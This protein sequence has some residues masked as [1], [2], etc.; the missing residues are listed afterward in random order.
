MNQR[1]LAAL[2]VLNAV[3]LAAL[4]V[5]VFSPRPAEAQFVGGSQ[6]LMI[7][8]DV[9]G[10]SQQAGVYIANL[11]SGQVLPILFNT[12]NNRLDTFPVRN[13]GED[14]TRPIRER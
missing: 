13:V 4:V 2:I 10:R 14:A 7:A 1:S 11:T 5:A 8:G 12:A 6:Y 3:L 9:V